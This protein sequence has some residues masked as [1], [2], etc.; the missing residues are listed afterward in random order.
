LNNEKLVDY[1]PGIY[2][3]ELI[4]KHGDS[5]NKINLNVSYSKESIFENRIKVLIG[6]NGTGKTQI[7]QQIYN[8]FSKKLTDFNRVI[9]VD[10]DL[11][12]LHKNKNIE[13]KNPNVFCVNSFNHKDIEF[14]IYTQLKQ[15][16]ELGRFTDWKEIFNEFFKDIDTGEFYNHITNK[17]DSLFIQLLSKLSS[18]QKMIFL[19]LVYIILLIRDKTLIILD[20]PETHLHPSAIFRLTNT[21]QELLETYNSFS[22]IATHSPVILQSIKSNSVI[23]VTK[24]NNSTLL[25]KINFECFGA[26]YDEINNL[27]FGVE[28]QNLIYK[29]ILSEMKNNGA[30]YDD[31]KSELSPN[32]TTPLSIISVL[33]F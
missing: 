23:N 28:D 30:S 6:E 19:T 1:E 8:H 31:I 3:N 7:L 21:I 22:L 26:S 32:K 5:T 16:I 14:E 13:D 29:R 12:K 20:E 25:Q 9:Y 18:G 10:Y 17:N 15:I 2:L 24:F 27:I 33:Y 4:I 11:F